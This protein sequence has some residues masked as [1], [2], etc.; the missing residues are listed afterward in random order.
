[1][2]WRGAEGDPGR[3]GASAGGAGGGRRGAGGPSILESVQ[4]DVERPIDVADVVPLLALEACR[5]GLEGGPRGQRWCV[6][7][8]VCVGGRMG[9]QRPAKSSSVRPHQIHCTTRSVASLGG[10]GARGGGGGGSPWGGGGGAD[11]AEGGGD[12]ILWLTT[13]RE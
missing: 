4:A 5:R 2:S 6:C 12:A 7:V 13:G 9:V 3:R 8:C 1:M 11:A 10:Q